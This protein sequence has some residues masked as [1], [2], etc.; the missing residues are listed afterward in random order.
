[1]AYLGQGGACGAK[2]GQDTRTQRIFIGVTL[3]GA[4]QCPFTRLIYKENL[5]ES[6]ASALSSS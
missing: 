6:L 5:L 3:V 4:S 1:M 2:I